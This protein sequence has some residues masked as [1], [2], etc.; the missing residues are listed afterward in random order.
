MEFL[1][2][3]EFQNI[4][5]SPPAEQKAQSSKAP[6]TA[7]KST[8]KRKAKVTSTSRSKREGVAS[9]GIHDRPANS[10]EDELD[11]VSA[12]P[13]KR[14]KNNVDTIVNSRDRRKAE[15]AEPRRAQSFAVIMIWMSTYNA[16]NRQRVAFR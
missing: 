9:S 10:V 8:G 12:P 6:E 4:E 5:E 7:Q 15:D 2:S 14:S 3:A 1:N 11:L 16:I 13:K